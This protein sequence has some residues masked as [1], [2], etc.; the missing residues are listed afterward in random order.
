MCL[1]LGY[2]TGGGPLGMLKQL[3]KAY[4]GLVVA[5][6]VLA[7]ISVVLML[8]LIFADV[9][10]RTFGFSAPSF[11]VALVEYSLIYFTVMAAP[12][13]VRIKGHVT[14]DVVVQ[15]FPAGLSFYIK[16]AIAIISAL[17]CIVFAVIATKLTFEAYQSGR[18]DVRGIDI[19]L[20][21]SFFPMP[22][23]FVLVAIEFL[24][25]LA[26]DPETDISEPDAPEGF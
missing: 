3:I 11:G 20:W 9:A 15:L 18:L 21:L 26:A 16:W 5:L 6:A 7:A 10:I 1:S 2:V 19:P 14:I 22:L 17:A 13:L 8:V 23:G 4:D 25:T 24:R 12:Y